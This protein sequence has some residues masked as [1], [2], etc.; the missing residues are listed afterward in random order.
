M[1]VLEALLKDIQEEKGFELSLAIETRTQDAN[2]VKTAM[3]GKEGNNAGKR[4]G[5]DKEREH[6]QPLLDNE[7]NLLFGDRLREN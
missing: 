2:V 6:D 1:C 7:A 5:S 4:P 3:G